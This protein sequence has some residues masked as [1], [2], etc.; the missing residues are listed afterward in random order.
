MHALVRTLDGRDAPGRPPA[1]AAARGRRAARRRRDRRLERPAR[2]RGRAPLRGC[3]AG[4]PAR[5]RGLLPPHLGRAV[6]GRPRDRR[7]LADPRRRRS[8]PSRPRRTSPSGSSATRT[9]TSSAQ[10]SSACSARR[11]RRV[12]SSTVERWSSA[13]PGLIDPDARALVL[14]QDAFEH[15]LG[16]RPLLDPHRRGD[17]ARLGARGRAASRRSCP[18]SRS[19]SSNIHSP[20]ERLVADVPAAR[21]G[22]RL[23]GCC[24]GS[25]ASVSVA[26]LT[27]ASRA[28]SPRSSRRTCSSASS[29]TSR[30]TRSRT[31]TS[32]SYPSRPEQLD[33]SRLLVDEL[34]EIGLD[35]VELTEHGY[36]L[37][38]LPGTV[39]G[40][41]VV[42]LIAHVDT[43]PDAPGAGVAPARA[44]RAG[45]ASRSCSRATRRRCSTRR[46][47][48]ALARQASATT[49]SRATGRRCSAPTTRPGWPRS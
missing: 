32:T 8:C 29:A 15:V 44:P 38:T 4:R 7:W 9:P 46:S 37:A 30:S 20:N 48:P 24:D 26:P 17:P 6:G 28:R 16:V 39:E 25:A 47:M 40:A 22:D 35:D 3:D 49:S 31:A 18:A 33:L 42:G 21:G 34:R 36:V 5:G 1:R 10:R 12:R 14:A 43:S 45:P 2:R 13:P 27:A 19:T 23:R 41:P 11:R